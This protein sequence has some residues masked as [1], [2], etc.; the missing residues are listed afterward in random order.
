M[1]TP[2]PDHAHHGLPGHAPAQP[3]PSLPPSVPASTTWRAHVAPPVPHANPVVHIEAPEPGP[4]PQAPTSSW[5]SMTTATATSMAMPISYTRDP[6]R[7]ALAAVITFIVALVGL[8]AIFAYLG[9][10]SD[11]L[12]SI[13]DGNQKMIAQLSESNKGLEGLERKTAYVGVMN[14]DAAELQKLMAGLDVDMGEMLTSVGSIGTQMDSMGR[15]LQQLDQG[16]DAA[17]ASSARIGTQLDSINQGLIAE[18]EKVATMR[19]DVVASSRSLVM[20]PPSL[21]AT[22]ARLGYI[23]RNVRFMGVNG[24]SNAARLRLS[25]LGIPNGTAELSGVIIPPG[26]WQ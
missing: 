26:A 21:R 4:A 19:G 13:V 10:M 17:N 20:L 24:V 12:T 8:W 9:K 11:T 14:K 16:L 3:W 15:S 5:S 6:S 22:N 25:L 2:S 18:A 23:N 1:S 7:T